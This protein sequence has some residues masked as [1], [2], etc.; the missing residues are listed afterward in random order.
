MVLIFHILWTV[1]LLY[2]DIYITEE[3]D[4]DEPPKKNDIETR[5]TKDKGTPEDKDKKTP[6]EIEL[7]KKQSRFAKAVIAK[8]ISEKKRENKNMKNFKEQ[9]EKYCS[10]NE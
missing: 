9:F 10:L 6:G 3:K 5:E 8:E 2:L 1:I 7:D 4:D